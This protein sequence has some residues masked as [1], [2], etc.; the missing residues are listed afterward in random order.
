MAGNFLT[1]EDIDV[2]GKTVLLRADLNV[3]MQGGRVTDNTRIVRL[4]PTLTYLLAKK[5]RVVILS[6]FGRPKGKFVP[7]LSLAPLVDALSAAL[8]GKDV[9]FGVD[10]V[11]Q[12]AKD[13][14]AAIAPGDIVLLENLRFHPQEE[15]GDKDFARELASLGDVFVNDAFSASHRAH[16]SITGIAEYLP[17]AAGRLMQEELSVIHEIFES[18]PKPIAAVV[19]GAKVSTKLALL[20]NLMTKMDV[21]VIGGA[22]ANTFLYAQGHDVGASLYEKDLKKTAQEILKTAEKHNCKIVLPVDVV[23]ASEFAAQAT[24]TINQVSDIPKDGIA[25]DIGPASVARFSEELAAC[26]TV[27]WNGPMGAFE[28]SPFDVSTVGLARVIASLTK[29]GKL[30]SIAGG[31]DTLAAL[32]HAGLASSFSYLTTG[33]GA[34]LEWLEGKPMPGIIALIEA[35]AKAA[36]A[37]KPMDKLKPTQGSLA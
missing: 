32:N 33:G 31:G 6:H 2:A 15:A 27:I 34:F 8:N 13:A 7:S 3:P 10:C 30:R 28:T 22:M 11:G 17:V 35:A 25:V 21:L 26:K 23:V 19:G 4:L 12:A 18:A 5:A 16:A 24:C 9:H 14:I 37:A 1:L 29:Q 20:Q 36:L